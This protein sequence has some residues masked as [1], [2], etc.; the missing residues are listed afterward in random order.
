MLPF[1]I[2]ISALPNVYVISY[3]CNYHIYFTIVSID[4]FS[5]VMSR[6]QM[7]EFKTLFEIFDPLHQYIPCCTSKT[8]NTSISQDLLKE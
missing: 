1:F 4:R 8:R 6:Q 3:F 2:P 7:L 5:E